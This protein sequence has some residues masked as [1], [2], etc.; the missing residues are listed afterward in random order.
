VLFLK[1]ILILL[2]VA[3]WFPATSHC[4]LE[5]VELI[6]TDECCTPTPGSLEQPTHACSDNCQNLEEGLFKSQESYLVAFP[7]LNIIDCFQPATC[8]STCFL[9][10]R[11]TTFEPVSV[12]LPQFLIRTSLPIRGP[13]IFS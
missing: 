3:I 10:T 5:M 8:E 6:P 2:L 12:P 1:R 4:L 13:S 7:A 11:S 9:I